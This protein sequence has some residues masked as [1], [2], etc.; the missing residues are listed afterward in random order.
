[1][2]ILNTETEKINW[3]WKIVDNVYIYMYTDT[4]IDLLKHTN[5]FTDLLSNF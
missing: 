4:F 2:Y 1:M 3:N 5:I